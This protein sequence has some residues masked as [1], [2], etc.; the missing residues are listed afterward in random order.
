MI[1]PKQLGLVFDS[2]DLPTGGVI[3]TAGTVS[4]YRVV[5]VEQTTAGQ[6]ISLPTP[7]DPTIVIGI[8]V[9]NTGTASFTIST[10]SVG[11]GTAAR[12]IWNGSAWSEV[13][14]TSDKNYVHTQPLAAASWNIGH[15][16]GK[17]PS[18]TAFD[19]TLTRVE[20]VENHIDSNNL[21]LTFNVP[22]SGIA[23]LN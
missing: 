1:A 21:E 11:I 10:S 14:S 9:V 2:P 6:T 5:L 12:L 7:S 19:S 20:G 8:D 23:S 15:N 3:L 13:G 22:V 18:V 17:Y 16:M 4:Q